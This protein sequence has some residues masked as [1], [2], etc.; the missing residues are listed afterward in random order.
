MPTRPAALAACLLIAGCGSGGDAGGDTGAEDGA[1]PVAERA[2]TPTPTPT[3]AP[4]PEWDLV[5]SGEGTALRFPAGGAHAMLLLCPAGEDRLLV[6]VPA[7]R[8]IASE[9]RLTF[10]SG[11]EAHALVADPRGDP[12][13]G[14]VSAEGAVPDNLAALIAGPLA[15]SYGAQQ[16]GP[17][18][19][20]PAELARG[21]V[22]GCG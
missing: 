14:G 11:A 7:L 15:A 6:N 2:Q 20:V 22:E 19:A 13:R 4:T 9:E 1:A 10:G 18:P 5:A 12:Q 8:A 3:P 21:L 17:H 16:S